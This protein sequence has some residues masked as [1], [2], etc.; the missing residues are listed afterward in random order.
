MDS[1][2][3]LIKAKILVSRL[4]G[5]CPFNVRT[6]AKALMSLR[7]FFLNDVVVEVEVDFL[8]WKEIIN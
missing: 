2:M 1:F 6:T 7:L 4:C 5:L 3:A 8:K